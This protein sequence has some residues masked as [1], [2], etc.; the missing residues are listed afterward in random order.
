MADKPKIGSKIPPFY[1]QDQKGLFVRDDDFLGIPFVLYFYP[2]DETPGCTQEACSFTDSINSF[3]NLQVLVIGVSP[4][5]AESH[6]KFIK[7]RKLS[8]SLL[9]DEKKDMCSMFDVLDARGNVI[10]TTF[11]IDAAGVICW[12]EKPVQIEGHVDRVLKAVKQHCKHKV[13][14]FDNFKRDYDRF[15]AGQ[16]ITEEDRAYLDKFL[17]ERE[18]KKQKE[19]KKKK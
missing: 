17:K 5:S 7:N 6:E 16:I 9:S 13:F 4:D 18:E 1:A 3:N 15:L 14:D 11:V 10:R 8:L 19:S 12:M 2:K